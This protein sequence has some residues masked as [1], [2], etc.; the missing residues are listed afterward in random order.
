MR[1]KR[2]VREQGLDR[3]MTF[4]GSKAIT[5]KDDA[6]TNDPQTKFPN[7]SQRDWRAFKVV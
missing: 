5:A 2:H 1:K 6:E 4:R 7:I 3:T